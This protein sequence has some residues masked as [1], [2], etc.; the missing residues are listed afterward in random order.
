MR[1]HHRIIIDGMTELH[2]INTDIDS[3][4][5]SAANDRFKDCIYRNVPTI[6]P[7]LGSHPAMAHLTRLELVTNLPKSLAK[8]SEGAPVTATLS[9]CCVPSPTK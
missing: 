7:T 9:T 6:R 8:M 4:S 5:L 1:H 3:S 2:R